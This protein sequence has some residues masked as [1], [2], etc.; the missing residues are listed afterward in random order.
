MNLRDKHD[1][2]TKVPGS[3][4]R[5]IK[6]IRFL[7]ERGLHVI[8]ANVLMVQNFA[9]YS[10]VRALAVDLGVE[11]T[12]DPTVTQMMD[13]NRC[14]L[15]LGIDRE[16]LKE[17]FHGTALVKELPES[18]SVPMTP[19]EEVLDSTPCRAG[20]TPRATFLRMVIF[21]RAFNFLCRQATY[22]RQGFWTS[23]IIL[24]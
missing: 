22:G 5:S 11:C 19:D 23:E 20:H 24:P 21:T 15:N 8:I 14:I 6:A 2:I 3:L 16:S 12:I 17:V 7:R 10:G 9:D 13:G 4:E 18:C 1:A